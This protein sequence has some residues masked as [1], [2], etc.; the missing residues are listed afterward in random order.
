MDMKKS[1]IQ[2]KR[3]SLSF[4]IASLLILGV[5]STP[6]YAAVPSLDQIRV[7]LFMKLPGKY[8]SLAPA[9]AF[10]SPGGMQ[11]GTRAPDGV[12]SWFSA[13]ANSE[14]RFAVDDYKARVLETSNFATALS[15]YQHIV[16]AKGTAYITSSAKSGAALYQVSEGAY[17]TAAE[18]VSAAARWSADSKLTALLKGYKPSAIGPYHLE[19]PAYPTEEAA[20]KAAQQFGAA[21]L[22]AYVAIR[23]GSKGGVQ[24][25]VMV[26]AATSAAELKVVQTASIKVPGGSALKEAAAGKGY[27]LKQADYSAGGSSKSAVTLY[28]FPANEMK[29]W[30]SPAKPE[31]AIKLNERSNR[32]YRGSFELSSFNGKLAVINELSFEEYLY[33]VVAVEMYTS[34]PMEALKA[35]AVAARTF[36]LQ[37]GFGFQ[38][39]HV[40]DTTLSQAYNGI[41]V[42][43]KSATDAVQATKGE[44]ILY[45]GKLIEA[46]YSSSAGGKTA[47]ASEAWNSS[48]PYLVSTASPDEISEQGLLHWYKVVLG[49][50]QIGYIREDLLKGTG[51]K[52]AADSTIME[53]TTDN[54]NVRR[55][56]VVQDSVPVVAILNKGD[57][58][59]VLEKVLQSNE[60]SWVR[61]PF[62]SP[63]LVTA[64][65]AR[66]N[67][68][69]TGSISSIEVTKRG[70]SGRALKIAVNGEELAVSSPDGFRSA[71][72]VQGAL[73]STL[74]TVAEEGKL[75]ILGAGGQS[76]TKTDE[77]QSV[78]V[79]GAAGKSAVSADPYLYVLGSKE[80]VRAVS[81]EATFSFSGSGFGH[82][83]GMS[84]YGAYALAEQGYDYAYILKYY[85]KDV[86]IEKD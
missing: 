18:A 81:K 46:L 14:A 45:N 9:A 17:A 78:Y 63:E 86:T 68:K 2:A 5:Q 71:L 15:V 82:G 23:A 79:I 47:D 40:V 31:Q 38:I 39:A 35:Q 80:Q 50:G 6:A 66:V 76:R 30:I 72:G 58:V 52:T 21:G 44:V 85:Y 37:K 61:G 3:L 49:S 41:G 33:S 27:F 57:Q 56:P 1:L 26:G 77:K 62:T 25:S 43:V 20:L 54:T 75:V 24:Y 51:R 28:S 36:A 74:F 7:A 11:I 42:E 16:S 10:S 8:E 32:S 48:I 34:W 22:D 65:N 19:S 73:P 83:V 64:I 59:I 69:I 70:P 67:P 13:A 84:Q 12:T 53:L 29:V 4:L 60:M 55:H